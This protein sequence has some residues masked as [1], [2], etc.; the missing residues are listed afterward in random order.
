MAT[1]RRTPWPT[2]NTGCLDCIDERAIRSGITLNDTLPAGVW[3]GAEIA[4][5]HGASLH[6][7]AWCQPQSEFTLFL[8]H[9]AIQDHRRLIWMLVR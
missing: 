3:F 7:S 8:L 4:F 1:V 5:R 9:C 6:Y 2:V